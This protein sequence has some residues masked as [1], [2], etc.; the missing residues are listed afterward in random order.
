MQTLKA[1]TDIPSDTSKQMSSEQ[2]EAFIEYLYV[3]VFDIIGF[4]FVFFHFGLL[5]GL[6]FVGSSYWAFR[7]LTRWKSLR[8][9]A[10]DFLINVP[11]ARFHSAVGKIRPVFA[12]LWKRIS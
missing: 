8:L 11:K 1:P 9:I 3:V 12:K 5:I 7:V 4:A 2:T 10:P 6:L